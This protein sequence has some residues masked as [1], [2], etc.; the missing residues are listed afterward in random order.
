MGYCTLIADESIELPET[1]AR[2]LRLPINE[3]SKKVDKLSVAAVALAAMLKQSG[4]F[5]L[6]AFETAITTFQKPAIAEINVKAVKVGA[7]MAGGD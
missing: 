6:E 7:E 4:M 1:K 2:I 3:T 5:S